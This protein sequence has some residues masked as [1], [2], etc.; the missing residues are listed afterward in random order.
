MAL[1]ENPTSCMSP[2]NW[3]ALKHGKAEMLSNSYNT[4]NVV[5]I[6]VLQATSYFLDYFLYKSVYINQA[7]LIT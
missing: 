6:L 2:Y 3:N 5:I 4:K 1:I 7:N